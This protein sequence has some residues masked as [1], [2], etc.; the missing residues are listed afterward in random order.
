MPCR[1]EH[2]GGG[3]WSTTWAGR[4]YYLGNKGVQCRTL[5]AVSSPQDP[6]AEASSTRVFSNSMATISRVATDCTGLR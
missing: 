1:P 5:R 3:P 6:R 4:C 2:E